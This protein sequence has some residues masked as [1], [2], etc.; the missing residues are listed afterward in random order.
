MDGMGWIAKGKRQMAQSKEK[1]STIPNIESNNQS[2]ISANCSCRK[3]PETVI[4]GALSPFLIEMM[5]TLKS[6]L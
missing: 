2:N 3:M 4:P 6:L 5:A 1:Y